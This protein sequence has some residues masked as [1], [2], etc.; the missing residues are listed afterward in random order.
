MKEKFTHCISLNYGDSQRLK[1]Y[2]KI[3]GITQ[4][5]I[6]STLINNKVPK[7]IPDKKFWELMNRHYAIQD[8]IKKNANGNEKILQAC[9]DLDK[10]VLEF[11][12]EM[13]LPKEA[14]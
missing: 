12:N 5:Q 10:W 3:S 2:A 13:L 14:A 6:V 8:S 11:Q 9:I 4:S 7:P 1:L